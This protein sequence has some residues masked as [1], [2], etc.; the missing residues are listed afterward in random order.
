MDES[1]YSTLLKYVENTEYT[2]NLTESEKR[3]L[4]YCTN[5]FNNVE[6]RWQVF[7]FIYIVLRGYFIK[8][9][10][11]IFDFSELANKQTN[12]ELKI[13]YTHSLNPTSFWQTV[14]F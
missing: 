3:K 1:A 2:E 5:E 12:Y 6:L 11:N 4:K 7:T 13:I 9:L 10:T 8:P 14:Y